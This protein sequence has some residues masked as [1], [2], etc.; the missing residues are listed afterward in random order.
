MAKKKETAVVEPTEG[1]TPEDAA[2]EDAALARLTEAPDDGDAEGDPGESA[3]DAAEPQGEAEPGQPTAA[4][5][6]H[7]ADSVY[8]KGCPECEAEEAEANQPAQGEG[9]PEGSSAVAVIPDVDGTVSTGEEFDVETSGKADPAKS[10]SKSKSKSKGGGED[11]QYAVAVPDQNAT[12]S[13]RAMVVSF[14]VNRGT[15]DVAVRAAA[16]VDVMAAVNYEECM[17]EKTYL[18]K[19]RVGAQDIDM[20]E[21]LVKSVS[22][23]GSGEDNAPRTKVGFAWAANQR[24]K[25]HDLAKFVGVPGLI[26]S[27]HQVQMTMFGGSE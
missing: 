25:A 21:C 5:E 7:I 19:L 2:A 3:T 9:A 20:G 22:T 11:E 10:K 24:N 26:I 16:E 15:N 17:G 27:L 14:G 18:F 8:E 13:T 4:H 12:V 1:P 6:Q 23:S